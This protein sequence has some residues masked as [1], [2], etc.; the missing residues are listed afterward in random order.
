MAGS[1]F[2]LSAHAVKVFAEGRI[3][4]AWVEHV[5]DKP[6]RIEASTF[7]PK[8]R[9]AFGRIAGYGNRVL[10]VVYNETTDPPLVVTAYFDRG[11]KDKS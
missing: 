6:E 4:I 9:S 3:K 11:Q 8:L 7:D 2:E 5:L 1:R 10:R